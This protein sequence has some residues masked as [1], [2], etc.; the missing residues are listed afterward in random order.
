[1]NNTI[2]GAYIYYTADNKTIA[3]KKIMKMLLA[4]GGKFQ[5]FMQIESMK[6][7]YDPL[8][9]E[10]KEKRRNKC[11]KR[12]KKPHIKSLFKDYS[13]KICDLTHALLK[14]QSVK[15]VA[16]YKATKSELQT[17]KLFTLLKN[18]Y[19]N[20]FYPKMNDD[21]NIDFYQVYDLRNFQLGKF[22]MLEPIENVK[23]DNINELD[24]VIIPG[25][26]FNSI[27]GARLGRGKGHY[28][29]FLSQI[30]NV[31]KIGITIEDFISNTLPS[32]QHDIPMD[33][34][35]TEL[36]THWITKK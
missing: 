16:I 14:V 6:Y 4:N 35:I 2:K 17:D 24:A 30:P 23:L 28:D 36:G 29:K 12:R 25:L 9:K 21:N 22:K 19:V 8:A 32:E 33:V 15:N 27:T 31:L 10:K 18:D 11:M 34:I 13:R 26:A 5:E 1:M 3:H 7:I 20:I